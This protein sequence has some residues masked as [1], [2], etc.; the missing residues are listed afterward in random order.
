MHKH[1]DQTLMNRTKPRVI[2]HRY[3]R[4]SK[5][6]KKDTDSSITA[7]QIKHTSLPTQVA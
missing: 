6:S 1:T 3:N 4:Q 7:P 5:Q 2:F